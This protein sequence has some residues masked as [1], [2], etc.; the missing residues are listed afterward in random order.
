MKSIAKVVFLGLLIFAVSG[1][2]KD[3]YVSVTVDDTYLTNAS[4]ESVLDTASLLRNADIALD[5]LSVFEVRINYENTTKDMN[6]R[7]NFN[8]ILEGTR[9]DINLV[10]NVTMGT[11]IFFLYTK[12]R[13]VN[14]SYP[15]NGI[16]GGIR[17]NM[18][19]IAAQLPGVFENFS[20]SEV[21]PSDINDY[22]LK[23]TFDG[24]DVEKIFEGFSMSHTYS[25][26]IYSIDLSKD[27]KTAE[28]TMDKYYRITNISSVETNSTLSIE[29]TYP[30]GNYRLTYPASLKGITYFSI[31]NA[32]SMAKAD[33][34]ADLVK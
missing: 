21:V 7:A 9:K 13:M 31:A 17:D 10:G 3:E 11:K 24:L 30:T 2:V 29:V 27:S 23:T 4:Y 6:M 33:S 8:V 1:C 15:F 19:N 22:L 28:V 14:V 5:N 20:A 25:N 34:L 16:N 32:L 26:E 18:D 12:D